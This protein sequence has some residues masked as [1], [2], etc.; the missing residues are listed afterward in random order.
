VNKYCPAI[1]LPIVPNAEEPVASLDSPIIV[2]TVAASTTRPSPSA[3]FFPSKG[4]FITNSKGVLV[5]DSKGDHS[6]GAPS[7]L[8]AARFS[9]DSKASHTTAV[10]TVI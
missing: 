4:A 3:I 6:K 5:S 7:I 1:Q 9:H 8:Q 10:K 2:E